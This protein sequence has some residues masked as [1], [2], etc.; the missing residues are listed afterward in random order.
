MYGNLCF[1]THVLNNIR[2]FCFDLFYENHIE[3]MK[4]LEGGKFHLK[5]TLG[6]HLLN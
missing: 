1:K 2:V 6:L 3:P 4:K 5:K